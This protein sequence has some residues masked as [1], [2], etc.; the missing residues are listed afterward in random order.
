VYEVAAAAAGL[1]RLTQA[2][3]LVEYDYDY[4]RE[5]RTA[6]RELKLTAAGGRAC[7]WH[8]DREPCSRRGRSEGPGERFPFRRER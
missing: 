2:L 4:D 5:S 6:R 1:L 8:W 3:G 7:S